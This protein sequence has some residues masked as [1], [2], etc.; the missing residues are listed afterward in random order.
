MTTQIYRLLVLLSLGVSHTGHGQTG[1]TDGDWRYFGGDSGSSKYSALDQIDAE[2]FD[3]LEIKWRWQSID[4][5]F[6]LEQL[7]SEY[8]NLLVANDV[9]EVSINGLKA[10]PLAIDGVLY[11]STPLYQAA[12]IDART[13][14]TLWTYD[15]RS[16]A[17]GIPIMMLG[18]SN[19]GLA[20]WSDGDRS[21]VVW[22][23]GDGYLLAVDAQ[24]GVAIPEFGEDGR[25]D[26]MVDIPRARRQA[27]INYS[28]T[29]SP[30]IIGDIIVVGAAIS[31]QPQYKE[32][33]PGHVRGFDIYT[34]D[35]LWTFHTI[36]QAGEFGNETWEDGSW[37]Y[38]GHTN[39][40]TLM[41]ADTE[42]GI[43]YLPVGSPTNDFYGG[44]RLGDN[45]FANSLVALDAK[46]GERL[47][48]FQMVHHD[49]WD[50]D[51]PAAPNLIDISVDGAVIKAVAQVTKHGFVFVFDRITG[52]PVWPIE[53][54]PVP[55]SDVPGERSSPTQPFPSKPPPFD[56]QGLGVDD[57]IDFTP[58]LR[59]AALALVEQH[60]TGPMFTPPSLLTASSFG[61]INVP[62]YIGG[63]N[64]TGAGIDPES[65]ILYIPSA[66]IP[67]RSG[68]AA[69][70]AAD[71]T[72]NYV[73]DVTTD[74]RPSGLPLTK[75]PYGRI[76]AID[77][78]IGSIL[79]QVPNGSGS[80][81]VRNH[82]ALADLELPPLGNGRDQ[83]LITKSLLISA[84]TTPNEE[85][86]YPLV[87][88]DKQTGATLAEL[89]LPAQP[90]GPPVTYLN[91][92]RQQLA[93]TVRGTPPEL[94]VMGLP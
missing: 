94:V 24:T 66:T 30:L 26:L 79:W 20:Y 71:A 93:I 73:R 19:R 11:I 37:E 48:H 56:R 33:P 10:A 64:W 16:Y 58:Q 5:R 90:I 91:N 52:E 68:L 31:D 89:G 23:T 42:A 53:E 7:K 29:S 14:E 85:G 18:F 41:S 61:T 80:P 1:M 39:V 47:W 8:P 88:R 4:G 45:L 50:S 51:P 54:R 82:P 40:W 36:P 74:L 72:L 92:G 63:A 87:A 21:R 2:N 35:L 84:Q 78:N 70:T 77:L 44:H 62:G 46:S 49:L 17:S 34:G 15:P 12:A 83:V 75:P 9:P 55:A 43:V 69:P 86:V 81:G 67:S 38:S 32:M 28:V 25:V 6:D 57:L 65:G 3:Q 60:R 13:G 59:N 76:T 22:G 27:P